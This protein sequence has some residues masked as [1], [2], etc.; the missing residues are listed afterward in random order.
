MSDIKF[1]TRCGGELIIEKV[2]ERNRLICKIC[3]KINYQNPIPV[4]VAV[5]TRSGRRTVG[6]VRR[7]I[8]PQIGKWALPGGFIEIDESP[9]EAILREIKEEIGVKGKVRG[10]IGVQSDDSELY[11][12][13]VVIGYEVILTEDDFFISD[14][15]QEFKFFPLSDHPPLAFPSH[16][17][18]LQKFEKTYRNPVPTV[19]A[20]IEMNEGIVLVRRKNPPYGWALPGG[21]VD[22]GETLEEAIVREVKEEINLKID[23]LSQFHTYSDPAR[24]PRLH[25]IST[26]FVVK[27]TGS[28]KA[29]DDAK[30]VRVFSADKLPDDIAFDHARIIRDYFKSKIKDK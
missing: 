5:L 2:D 9:E 11:G 13:V 25:T 24:D 14:E 4:V 17:I 29:G 27:A 1:C 12:K 23:K 26:V 3:R 16:T 18:I 30:D 6:L 21:F 15:V 28:L 20:I 19:D 22:Y 10:L 8:P 7:A